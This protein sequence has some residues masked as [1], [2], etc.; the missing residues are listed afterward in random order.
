M[1]NGL[2]VQKGGLRQNGNFFK[3]RWMVPER[4]RYHLTLLKILGEY[5]LYLKIVK[6]YRSGFGSGERKEKGHGR[7]Q[8]SSKQMLSS[9]TKSMIR[10]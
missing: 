4:P 7:D 5:R 6:L 1:V 3:R 10:E 2:S 8:Q 9:Q